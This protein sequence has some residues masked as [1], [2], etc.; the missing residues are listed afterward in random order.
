MNEHGLERM[1]R[2]ARAGGRLIKMAVRGC[3]LLFVFAFLISCG[4]YVILSV[5]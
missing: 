1:E 3:L 4:L 2:E 5:G